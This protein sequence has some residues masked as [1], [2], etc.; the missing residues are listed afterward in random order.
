MLKKQSKKCIDW[1]QLETPR[2]LKESPAAPV[3]DTTVVIPRQHGCFHEL[4]RGITS[5][6]SRWYHSGDPPTAW[7]ISWVDD[8]RNHQPHQSLVPQWWFP[9]SMD[10]FMSVWLE[11]S[12]A[13]P[14]A[15]TTV[16]I[17]RQHGWFHEL[18]RGITSR[19]SHPT[20]QSCYKA[21]VRDTLK[22]W[23]QL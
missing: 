12:P 23:K 2:R 15:G 18:I 8:K 13:A 22:V 20:P 16:V 10:D 5:R 14:V 7:M 4:I 1:R 21:E 3:A 19:T 6:T 11:E 9:D 17:P